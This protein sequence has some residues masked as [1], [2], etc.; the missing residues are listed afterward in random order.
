MKYLDITTIGPNS[1]QL[2]VCRD[3]TKTVVMRHRD[4]GKIDCE[5]TTSSSRES[6]ELWDTRSKP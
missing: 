2:W 4:T 5:T 1:F 3:G 6:T